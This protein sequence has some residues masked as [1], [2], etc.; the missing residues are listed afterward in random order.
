MPVLL[1]AAVPCTVKWLWDRSA[2]DGG[3]SSSDTC[4]INRVSSVDNNSEEHRTRLLTEESNSTVDDTHHTSVERSSI[5]DSTSNDDRP[6][7]FNLFRRRRRRRT[8]DNNNNQK[9]NMCLL[10]SQSVEDESCNRSGCDD[11]VPVHSIDTANIDDDDDNS[12]C[13]RKENEFERLLPNACIIDE[14]ITTLWKRRR[15]WSIQSLLRN[16][17]VKQKL[18]KCQA[19]QGDIFNTDR[20]KA[21]GGCN[22]ERR[23]VSSKDC[24]QVMDVM[25]TD[26]KEREDLLYDLWIRD[27]NDLDMSDE[28]EFG[29]DNRGWYKTI[30]SNYESEEEDTSDDV[31]TNLIHK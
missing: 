19:I 27:M 25:L 14:H 3:S 24:M 4:D 16:R 15:R 8:R 6:R 21:G 28:P 17:E 1:I 31:A 7:L 20:I 2:N 30:E 22:I 18:I 13:I 10:P 12:S 26:E 23:M 11:I 5:E 29:W 9:N